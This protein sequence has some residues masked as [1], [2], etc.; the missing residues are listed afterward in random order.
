MKKRIWIDT[1]PGFD[2]L[3]SELFP[4]QLAHVSV[5]TSGTHALGATVCE[6]R[7]PGRA[8]PNARVA[9]QASGERAIG[10]VVEAFARL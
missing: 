4:L 7:V 10:L 6:F 8:E 9:I 1:D 2:D 3:T 5:E